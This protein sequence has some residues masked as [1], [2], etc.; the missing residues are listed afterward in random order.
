MTLEEKERLM[1]RLVKRMIRVNTLILHN[2]P[3]PMPE[4]NP[5]DNKYD[6]IGDYLLTV[7]R[8]FFHLRMIAIKLTN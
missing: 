6:N 7:M 1:L 3:L 2:Q 5:I 4:I 8:P